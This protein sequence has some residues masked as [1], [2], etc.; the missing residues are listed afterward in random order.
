MDIKDVKTA[1][2]VKKYNF[3]FSKSLGQNFLVDDSVPRD[4]VSGAE[5]DENDLVIE[6][7][8][9]VGTL[10]AQLLN[11]AKKVV[12][13]ELD[14]DLIPI[15]TQEIGDNPKFTLIH[16]DALKVDFN[17][18][19]GEEKS[20]K[21]VANLPYY[22]TTPIIVKLLKENYNFKS[23]TIMIQK[24][25]AERMNAE[26]GNK[27]YGSLSL[28]VQYYCNTRIVRKVPPQC[29]MPRPKVDSI[30]IRLD[31]LEE[32]KVKVENEKLF[33][34]IIRSSFNMRRKTLWNGV[35]NV[36]L[37]KE[38]LEVAFK[39]ADIDPKRRGET[40]TIDEFA[41]LSDKINKYLKL[42]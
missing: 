24:E 17:E 38:N 19:I 28:L 27:D 11:K 1:E 31:R 39:E 21:L 8:P 15:L 2:L 29:F 34:E 25:V 16:K 33:F 41:I 40:L 6:I 22:V 37:S 13:I 4:I 10:T 5:V 32:P 42:K 12:A 7:G 36:G 9:G 20:V 26:P 3:K 18:I 14:N 35:K 30:V 23:L